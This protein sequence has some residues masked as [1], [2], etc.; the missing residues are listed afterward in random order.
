MIRRSGQDSDVWPVVLLLFAVLVPAVCLLW[1]M[2]AA[3]RNE[4]FADRQRLADAYRG[5]LVA[6]QVRLEKFWEE[7]VTG[8]ERLAETNS[9]SAAFAR[10]VLSGSVDSVVILDEQGRI[11]Y[12]NTPSSFDTVSPE[13]EIKWTEASQLEFLRKDFLTAAKR[14]EALAA[15]ATNVNVAARALQAEARCLVQAERK[16]AA[17]RIVNEILGNAR[18]DHATDPQGRL[19]VANAEL[20]VL[21]LTERDSS[22]FQSAAQRLGK[23]LMDYENSVFAAPQRRFL[24]KELQKLSPRKIE[25][26]TMAAEELAARFG[27]EHPVFALD[28]ALQ[29][30]PV[31]D[32]WQSITPNH[33]VVALVRSEKLLTGLQA[34][35]ADGLPASEQLNL[36]PPGAEKSDALVWLSAGPQL[37][38][39]HLALS[40]KDESLLATTTEHRT[41]IYFWT[42]ILVIAA[43]GILTLLAVRLLRRQAALARLKNDLVATVSHELKTPLSSMRVLLDTLLDSDKRTDQKTREYLQ[44]VAQENE[45]L[46]RLI[47]NFL[48]FSRMERQ[49][50]TFHFESLPASQIVNAAVAAVHQRFAA[51]DCHFEVQVEPDLP[52][53][54]ADSEAMPTALINL[55]DNAWKYS[56]DAK[57]I[58]LRARASNGSVAFSVQDNGIGIAPRETKKIFQNFYQVD[59][60]LSRR[61]SGCG[62]G[63][64]IVRFIVTAHRGRVSVESAPDHGST[65]TISL[66]AAPVATS[67][68]NSIIA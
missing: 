51:A 4:R 34:T 3:M 40:L 5:Q 63:L 44:L 39:W 28:S 2:S 38:G 56:D 1:F 61:T 35:L 41:A 10:C 68:G 19:I 48:T 7:T 26:P 43:M 6:S 17:V 16:D 64:S 65:F 67:I 20:M 23:R 11:A 50:Y 60:R 15:E 66:P 27:D 54:L 57:R 14:Y 45:R 30:T 18:F 49:K 8:L 22:P 42:A 59:Q 25:F 24:M 33:R 37:P 32:L 36:L 52:E 58:T 62:L 55:L 31:V 13:P 9:P 46:S 21:E 29:N 47:E 53:I 12:P